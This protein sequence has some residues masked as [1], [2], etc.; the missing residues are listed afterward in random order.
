MPA[1]TTE[2][3]LDERRPVGS[4]GWTPIRRL[5]MGLARCGVSPNAISMMS[6]AFAGA[7]AGAA[8]LAAGGARWPA[9]AAAAL[10]VQ[11]RLL[12][13]VL[14]GLVAIEGGRKGKAGALFNEAPDRAADALFFVG[15][16]L[17]A[18]APHWGW[19]AALLAVFVA[20]VRAFGASLGAGQD[21]GGPC[22]KQQ[23]MFLLTVGLLAACWR[24]DALRWTLMA[25]VAGTA[26]TAI[27]RLR[28]LHRRLP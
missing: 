9:L 13:N 2:A 6:V 5:A 7:G 1:G 22:A 14:D 12:C 27:L 25:V 24:P 26:L 15:A 3:P 4:R 18:E 28:R 16:G 8:A 11:G 19:A 21:F 10:C 17:A 20:Y 23:R